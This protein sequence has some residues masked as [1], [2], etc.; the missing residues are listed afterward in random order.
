[1]FEF[2]KTRFALTDN[3]SL[4]QSRL[5][6]LKQDGKPVAEFSEIFN[7]KL[8]ELKMSQA[9]N[10]LTETYVLSAFKN[11]LDEAYRIFADNQCSVK[12][13]SQ[14]VE[15]LIVWEQ[16]NEAREQR[17]P[18]TSISKPSKAKVHITQAKRCPV[19]DR[20]FHSED[21][22]W[23]LHPELRPAKCAK[24]GQRH[25]GACKSSRIN[26]SEK[27]S[28][29]AKFKSDEN[30]ILK[31][32]LATICDSSCQLARSSKP[33]TFKLE[34]YGCTALIDSGATSSMVSV[35]QA[36]DILN[37]FE[38]DVE[39]HELKVPMTVEFGDSN[40][41]ICNQYITLSKVTGETSV[42][43]LVVPKLSVPILIG[44]TD[45]DSLKL[46]QQCC[47]TC[48][49]TEPEVTTSSTGSNLNLQFFRNSDGTLTVTSPLFEN[50]TIIP[51]REKSRSHSEVELAIMDDL[52][53]N[54]LSEGKI[55]TATANELLIVQELILVDKFLT[56]GIH[57]PKSLPPEE[58]RFRL[59]LDCRLFGGRQ[60][61]KTNEICQS[62]RSALAQIESISHKN[63]KFFAKIDLKNAFYS[64]KVTYKLSQLFGF[65]HRGDYF[66]FMVLP[67]GWFLSPTIFQ[68]VVSFMIDSA[69]DSLV[70]VKVIH[71]QDDILIC[72]EEFSFVEQAMKTL[73]D[74][75]ASFGFSVRVEKCEGPSDNSSFCGLKVYSDGSVKPFP[76]KRQLN[77]IAAKTAVESFEKAKS[78]EDTKHILRSW[79]GTSNYFSKWLPTDLRSE[80]LTLH[81]FLSKL[82][83]GEIAKQEI[84][85]RASLFIKSLCQWWLENASAIYGG[86]NNIENTLVFVDANVSGWSGCIFHLTEVE[87]GIDYPLPF[88]LSG[89]LSQHERD[90][91]PEGKSV[92]QFTLIPVRFDGARF[93]SKFETQQ[94]STWRERA[95][96]MMIVHRNKEVLSGKVL[97][98]SDN[99]N[100][101]GTWKDTDSLNSALCSSFVTYIS[102]VHGAIH[103]RRSHPILVWIDQCA[104]N[105]QLDSDQLEAT[106]LPVRPLES[107][108]INSSVFK[109]LKTD[110][111]LTDDLADPEVFSTEQF[112]G[113]YAEN[114]I[115]PLLSKE[116]IIPEGKN[117]YTTEKFPGNVLVHSLLIPADQASAVLHAI[118]YDYG[119]ATVA[120]IRKYLSLWKIWIVNFDKLVKDILSD[121]KFCLYCREPYH[122]ERSSIPMPRRPM[123]LIMADFLQPEKINQPAFIVF[124]DRFSGYTEGRAIEKMDQFEVRQLLI[125]W[126]ARFGPPSVFKTDNGEAF[127]SDLMRRLYAK[128]HIRHVNSPGYEPKSNG[129]VERVIKSVEEGLRIELMAGTPAQEAI[130]IVTG[131]LNRTMS[132]PGDINS[133]SPREIIFKFNEES[134]FFHRVPVGD[135]KHDLNIGQRVLMKLPNA[136][137]LSPQ[138]SEVHYFISDIIGNHIYKLADE[139]GIPAKV[140]IRR[141]RLK[142]V[143]PDF[144]DNASICSIVEGGMCR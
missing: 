44:L 130:H 87:S 89:V 137:K 84:T 25:L 27:T 71:Q 109:K 128:Y 126:I 40:K 129:A 74:C 123:D 135:F 86:S 72:G 48:Q 138:F 76:I 101:V 120:G 59:V 36:V 54:M 113:N 47:D 143:S 46:F 7:Q 64:T 1:L 121:C 107:D 106:A 133:P 51:W 134:P 92:D 57:K 70:N 102:H 9:S 80:C 88:S 112:V 95:A 22:C 119:H 85:D 122:P 14:M 73:I 19:C 5:E 66:A 20:G 60:P 61:S 144:D 65:R 100:L 33:L 43:F 16:N 115:E 18:S 82:N 114:E 23:K 21:Q 78:I 127:N 108:D 97:I 132:V 39:L 42:D 3:S 117:F 90:L 116:W 111:L 8:E 28:E 12:S 56:K 6:K 41:V 55:R 34:H 15:L 29:L 141:E 38:S 142:P 63:R 4:L 98:L 77:E 52:V 68:D 35:Q 110:E 26:D 50:A 94:S 13:Y 140:S 104:R 124:R 32:S 83:S 125:E 79:L 139:N 53:H 103:I 11:S 136:S 45:F 37:N 69:S 58:G 96:A 10:P 91:I 30:H 31:T 81:S 131:R 67:M 75:F 2:L 49:S 62:Q 118:H 93:N 24:C 99:K 17:F 105:L